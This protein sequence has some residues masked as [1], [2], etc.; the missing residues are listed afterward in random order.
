M[1]EMVVMPVR[2]YLT[3]LIPG[4]LAF[5]T[6]IALGERSVSKQLA[7]VHVSLGALWEGLAFP[8]LVG[9]PAN[10]QCSEAPCQDLHEHMLGVFLLVGLDVPD[11]AEVTACEPDP[12][13]EHASP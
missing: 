2:N 1:M 5:C 11:L 4:L 13:D 8:I 9:P 3:M 6:S 12:L 10:R 7:L